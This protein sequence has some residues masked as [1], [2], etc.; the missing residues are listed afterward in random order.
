MENLIETF[1]IDIKLII[2]QMV[3]FTIVFL[4]LYWFAFKPIAKVMSERTGKIEKSLDDA[5]KIETKLAQAQEEF[6]KAVNEAKKQANQ[7]LEKAAANAD[8]K[9]AEMI[10]RAKEEIG[11][12]INQERQK[13]QAEKRETLKEI[14]KEVADLVMLTVEK[15]LEDKV[16]AKKNR[17]IIKRIIKS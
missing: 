3:N 5:K 14:K 10:T 11:Q 2:A 7:I 16:D 8:T 4:V 15:I 13:M 17:E 6:D 12:I 9:K 1:H